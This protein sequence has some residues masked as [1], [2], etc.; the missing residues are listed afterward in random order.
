MKQLGGWEN[1]TPLKS[2]YRKLALPMIAYWEIFLGHGLAFSLPGHISSCVRGNINLF[3][4]R[5]L[6]P[7][8]DR[9]VSGHQRYQFF[10]C[11]YLSTYI[12]G[13]K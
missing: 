1:N 11:N 4:E 5:N 10:Q 6:S 13:L 7:F 3:C 9:T 2:Q 12:V 8:A